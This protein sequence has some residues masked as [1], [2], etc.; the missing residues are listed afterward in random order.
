MA[1]FAQFQA[2]IDQCRTAM[3]AESYLAARKY[4]ATARVTLLAIPDSEKTSGEK[5]TFQ[6]QV[7]DL[8]KAIKELERDSKNST[9]FADGPLAF[10]MIDQ[11]EELE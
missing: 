9:A 4:L 2:E 11:V 6:R 3:A 10:V 7:D 1:T 8:Q 5:I